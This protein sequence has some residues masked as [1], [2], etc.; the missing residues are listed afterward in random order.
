MIPTHY[1][2][3]CILALTTLKIATLVVEASGHVR[4]ERVNKWPS[5]MTDIRMMIVIW[6]PVGRICYLITKYISYILVIT[7]RTAEVC[8]LSHTNRKA[9]S[10]F[11][12]W[13]KQRADKAGD[14]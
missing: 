2:C 3:I 12:S 10:S 7:Y 1:K 13:Q 5:S 8:L 6:C 4:P 14:C 9:G 11:F